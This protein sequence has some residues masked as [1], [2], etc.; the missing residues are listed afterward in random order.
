MVEATTEARLPWHFFLKD[1]PDG[2]IRSHIEQWRKVGWRNLMREL[3]TEYGLNLSDDLEPHWVEP[4][5]AIFWARDITISARTEGERAGKRKVVGFDED[6]SAWKPT[7]RLPVGNASQL[8]YYIQKKGFRLRPLTDGL[9]PELRA[10]VESAASPEKPATETFDCEKHGGN[11]PSWK[12]YVRHCNHFNE[13]PTVEPPDST[14]M[15]MAGAEY[16][17]LEHNFTTNNRRL[18]NRHV[19]VHARK[20]VN[21]GHIDITKMQK[22]KE[23]VH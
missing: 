23:K 13:Q 16:Y 7:S 17:C 11:F 18:A 5:Y 22:T 9:E 21:K 19:K 1:D 15:A 6:V 8:A 20:K 14:V 3:R 2:S 4:N 10:V 12:G